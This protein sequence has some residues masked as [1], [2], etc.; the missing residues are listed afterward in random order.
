MNLLWRA[1]LRIQYGLIWDI[2]CAEAQV[3]TRSQINEFETSLFLCK[4]EVL[5]LDVPAL[6]RMQLRQKHPSMMMDLNNCS[7][8]K[9]S[10]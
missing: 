6:T 4:N 9:V 8:R 7:V 3:S 2:I 10:H 5:W 1:V